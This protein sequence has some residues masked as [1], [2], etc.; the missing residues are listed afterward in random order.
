MPEITQE[1]K[2][3][4]LKKKMRT[5]INRGIKWLDSRTTEFWDEYC[6]EYDLS[7]DEILN[8]NW[9]HGLSL[10]ALD[11]NDG[12]VCVLGQ[13]GG[14]YAKVLEFA[15]LSDEEASALGFCLDEGE[16][17]EDFWEYEGRTS[18]CYSLLTELWIA[19]VKVLR[20]Q[21]KVGDS[22]ENTQ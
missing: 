15:Y 9:L 22:H 8:G 7:R 12:H 5:R 21:V 11:L 17:E 4:A 10:D 14:C 3:V 18:F 6:E 16:Y 19:E 20:Q 1:E 13:T 2:I